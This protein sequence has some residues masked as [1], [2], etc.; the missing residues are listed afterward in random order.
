MFIT[1]PYSL[2]TAYVIDSMIIDHIL[3]QMSNLV[4]LYDTNILF[5]LHFAKRKKKRKK[6]PI[7]LIDASVMEGH[8]T[9]VQCFF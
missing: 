1:I 9:T 8:I 2:V 4:G 3:A 6:S 5:G 7:G